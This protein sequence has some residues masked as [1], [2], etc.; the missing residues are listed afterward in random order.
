VSGRCADHRLQQER[1]RGS[2]SQRHYGRRHQRQRLQILARDPIC[3]G[4]E[5]AESTVDDHIVRIQDGGSP[6][7]EQ[8]QQGLCVECH[9]WKTAHE[10]R[11]PFFGVRLRE[12]GDRI[13]GPAPKGWRYMPEFA[14]AA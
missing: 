13:G 3:R 2:A 6:T 11:D 8:N 4:C 5:R 7:D 12:A 14:D 10:E 9:G 1:A